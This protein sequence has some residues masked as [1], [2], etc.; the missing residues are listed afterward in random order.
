[1]KINNFINNYKTEIDIENKC[2]VTK[3]ERRDKG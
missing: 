1:M 3:R 2:K